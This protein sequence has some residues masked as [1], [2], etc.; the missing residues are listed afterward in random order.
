M[1]GLQAWKTNIDVKP[2]FSRYKAVTYMCTYFSKAEDETSEAMK[3]K[4]L[5]MI[6]NLIMKKMEIIARAYATKTQ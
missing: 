2:V 6:R 1:E 3:Q 5:C 4:R